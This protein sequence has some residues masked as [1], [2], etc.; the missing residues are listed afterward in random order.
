MTKM[1]IEQDERNLPDVMPGTLM[2]HKDQPPFIVMA[3]SIVVGDEFA[4]V[5]IPD[6]VHGEQWIIDEYNVFQGIVK[7]EQ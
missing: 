3:T 7:L 1:V 4:G 2:I 5:S 6:G